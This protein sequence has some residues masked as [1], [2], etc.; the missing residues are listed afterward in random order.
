MHP[1][2][3]GEAVELMEIYH[4]I[5]QH[6]IVERLSIQIEAFKARQERLQPG[7]IGLDFSE[8]Y[9]AAI[10][11]SALMDGLWVELSLNPSSFAPSEAVSLCDDWIHALAAGAF[12]ALRASKR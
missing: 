3:R 10:G 6:R 1:V 7:I 2:Q 5:Q 9:L 11:L 12:P 8:Y 4:I